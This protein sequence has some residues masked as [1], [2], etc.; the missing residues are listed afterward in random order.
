[1]ADDH[2]S[3]TQTPHVIVPE[4]ALLAP[5]P[6]HLQDRFAKALNIM[7]SEQ[8]LV[9]NWQQ[10]AEQS[11]I[12]PAHFHRQFKAL[13]HETPGRYLARQQLCKA[14][15]Q[16]FQAPERS[17][18]EIAL[19]CGFSSSQALA[20]AVKRELGK[21]AK[22]LRLMAS[23]ATPAQTT[24]IIKKL[25][26]PAE[27]DTQ[28]IR[29]AS[30]MSLHKQWFDQ[31]SMKVLK[32]KEADWDYLSEH[33]WDELTRLRMQTPIRALDKNWRNIKVIVGDTQA[34]KAS[35]NNVIPAGFYL[36]TEALI[37]TATAYLTALE[38]M[39]K[40]AEEQ[41]YKIDYSGDLV[42]TVLTANEAHG[43]TFSFQIPLKP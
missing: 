4:L 10:I 22:E 25:S 3:E 42:E 8:G 16:L 11:A 28:E 23:T 12:S 35:H 41:G 40:L 29:L 21:T 7:H 9:L 24:D 34:I 13:F 32:V 17:I 36:C 39:F 5:L 15:I 6:K 14:V 26:Q 31:R 1:M 19:D 2:S 18:T 27:Q 20:K 37:A 33:H 38:T 30:Q 43:L